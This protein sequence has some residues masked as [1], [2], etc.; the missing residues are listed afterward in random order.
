MPLKKE[1]H[2]QLILLF[3]QKVLNGCSGTPQ[4]LGPKKGVSLSRNIAVFAKP[5]IIA[6]RGTTFF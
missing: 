2:S 6:E 1:L 4:F 5:S 3:L